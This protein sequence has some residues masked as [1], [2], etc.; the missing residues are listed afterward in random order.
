MT[1]TPEERA[2]RRDSFRKMSAA[3]KIEYVYSYYWLPILLLLVALWF[4]GYT[5]YRQATKK[6]V[7]LYAAYLNVSAGDDLEAQLNEEFLSAAGYNPRKN[8][9]YLY[10]ALYLSDKPTQENLQYAYTSNLKLLAAVSAEQLDLVLMNGEAYDILSR[11]GY[12]LELTEV[13]PD[14]LYPVLEP[15]LT[16]NGKSVNGLDVSGFPLFRDAAFTDSVYV[17][18][19]ANSSRLS[20]VVQ[21]IEYLMDGTKE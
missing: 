16:T 9:V 21:Y 20:T 8:E 1:L 13:L 12:L 5:I 19:I 11:N 6:D 18:V 3:D 2:A 17:G 4:M 15:H 7:V 14:S 10:R